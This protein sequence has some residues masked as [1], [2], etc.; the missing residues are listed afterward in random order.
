[1]KK[2]V[3]AK[4]ESNRLRGRS[5]KLRGHI[6]LATAVYQASMALLSITNPLSSSKKTPTVAFMRARLI[7]AYDAIAE[8]F[9][10]A[11]KIDGLQGDSLTALAVEMNP[12]LGSFR[13]SVNYT[14][15]NGKIQPLSAHFHA[16]DGEN[17]FTRTLKDKGMPEA[18]ALLESI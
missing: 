14:H 16:E 12:T 8:T 10:A 2:P 13:I 9:E 15:S 1:M 5:V 7:P 17:L 4:P 3:K 11:F 18:E 6:R